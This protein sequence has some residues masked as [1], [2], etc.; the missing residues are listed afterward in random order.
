MKLK[1]EKSD[2]EAM[3][4]LEGQL[5]IIEDD[6]KDEEEDE[7]KLYEENIDPTMD[8][9]SFDLLFEIIFFINFN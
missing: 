5:T 3:P 6:D 8:S 9:S 7:M 4:V 1:Q 2:L